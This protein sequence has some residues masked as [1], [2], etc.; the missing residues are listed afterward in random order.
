[1]YKL[2]LVAL[3]GS[4]SAHL[5]LDEALRLARATDATLIV[6]SVVVHDLPVFDPVLGIVEAQALDPV[7][8]KEAERE[9]DR[10]RELCAL[11]EVRAVAEQVD[12][13]G[14]SIPEAITRATRSFGADLIVM[15]THGRGGLRRCLLGSVAEAVLRLS[16]VPVLVLH[17]DAR[18]EDQHSS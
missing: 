4:K 12:A 8:Q 9:L 5:A 14:A 13:H 15:G 11:R 6:V 17:A 18:D 2:I 7:A 10:A 1:M 3:D 16:S